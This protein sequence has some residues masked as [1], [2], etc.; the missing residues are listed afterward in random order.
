M[1]RE[2]QQESID[3]SES[4]GF[5]KELI[6]YNDDFNTFDFVIDTLIEVC[7]HYPEQAEQCAIVAH[8]KGKCGVKTGEYEELI[9]IHAEM[10]K[11]GLTTKIE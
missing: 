3:S 11:R 2:K 5:G 4:T 7:S 6:L 9:P 10:M 1:I 8:T